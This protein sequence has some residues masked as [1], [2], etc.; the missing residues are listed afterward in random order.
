[1][2][3]CN[4]FPKL[5]DGYYLY[6]QLVT[7]LLC[8]HKPTKIKLTAI[9]LTKPQSDGIWGQLPKSLQTVA[10]GHDLVAETNLM[11]YDSVFIKL[12]Q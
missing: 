8:T 5:R 11:E 3:R 1:M 4:G 7:L 12:V 10:F 6:R 9:P 2:S